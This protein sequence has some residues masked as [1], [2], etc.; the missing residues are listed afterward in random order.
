MHRVGS[1]DSTP[2]LSKASSYDDMRSVDAR[3]PVQIF[4][5]RTWIPEGAM[6]QGKAGIA[7]DIMNDLPSAAQ[8]KKRSRY[9]SDSIER[10]ANS[11]ARR[12]SLIGSKERS[13]SIE[14]DD[15]RLPAELR[16]FTE[17]MYEETRLAR[18]T[19]AAILLSLKDL[20][21][22]KGQC[23]SLFSGWVKDA[24]EVLKETDNCMLRRIIID[25]KY[26]KI[27]EEEAEDLTKELIKKITSEMI[28]LQS[29]C[30]SQKI[31]EAVDFFKKECS[32]KLD[33]LKEKAEIPAKTQERNRA[34]S[35]LIRELR[36][37]KNAIFSTLQQDL[38]T[39]V[40]EYVSGDRPFEDTL[41]LIDSSISYARSRLGIDSIEK[42]VKELKLKKA[43]SSNESIPK[44]YRGEGHLPLETQRKEHYMR[45]SGVPVDEDPDYGYMSLRKEGESSEDY[46]L[47]MTFPRKSGETDKE[48]YLRLA[49]PRSEGQTDSEY[50]LNVL[51]HGKSAYFSS[52]FG[53]RRGES[54]E[55]YF[56]RVLFPRKPGESDAEHRLRSAPPR[57]G[58][59]MEAYFSRSAPFRE[60]G[61]Q[62]PAGSIMKSQ[63]FRQLSSDV[64]T[65]SAGIWFDDLI[66]IIYPRKKG[67]TREEYYLRFLYPRKAGESD[68]EYFERLISLANYTKEDALNALPRKEKRKL[69]FWRSCNRPVRPL[70]RT[71]DS[72]LK[73]K[74]NAIYTRD[75]RWAL[76]S[77]KQ[78][79]QHGK[80]VDG[81]FIEKERYPYRGIS[82]PSEGYSTPYKDRKAMFKA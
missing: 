4:E 53:P 40:M 76:S 79:F 21:K 47:R 33:L 13:N 3:K 10:G 77:G 50:L 78:N 17:K 80:I 82:A 43:S 32:P 8:E 28:D 29:K 15:D 42:E 57:E 64:T 31:S 65:F 16:A 19:E 55:E 34:I 74:V 61:W 66:E 35:H 30:S 68:T 46:I 7:F 59:S 54:K 23:V 58:E 48:Y 27:S 49:C 62:F 38:V 67:E 14:G 24:I 71:P 69:D 70:G 12:E 63:I 44:I 20:E 37:F 25:L 60:G 11:Q 56:S 81:S 9:F 39:T 73:D 6:H 18:E 5:Q 26:G 75:G 2:S 72:Q 22:E 41:E 1:T 36:S 51:L 52:V 45:A